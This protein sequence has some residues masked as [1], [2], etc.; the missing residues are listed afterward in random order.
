MEK[1]FS[2]SLAAVFLCLFGLSSNVVGMENLKMPDGE[3]DPKVVGYF[4]YDIKNNKP[5]SKEIPGINKIQNDNLQPT[6][7]IDIINENSGKAINYNGPL[8][9]LVINAS[10]DIS[11]AKMLTS[12]LCHNQLGLKISQIGG[13]HAYQEGDVYELFGQRNVRVIFFDVLHFN[14]RKFMKK[15]DPEFIAKNTNIVL[16]LIDKRH[17]KDCVKQ[18]ENF[19]HNFNHWWCKDYY[20]Y[21]K[22]YKPYGDHR[23]NWFRPVLEGMKVTTVNHR[24]MYFLYY[25]TNLERDKFFSCKCKRNNVSDAHDPNCKELMYDFVSGMPDGRSIQGNLFHENASIDALRNC[26]F[27]E[28]KSFQR[29]EPFD[30]KNTHG[31]LFFG[32][33]ETKGTGFEKKNNMANPWM[34]VNPSGNTWDYWH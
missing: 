13:I 28:F 18:L 11:K 10:D 33:D 21:D 1:S 6:S 32:K 34:G 5:K 9:I 4:G 22:S 7:P 24:Y 19:Y 30:E 25:G 3:A 23:D 17:D 2:R 26:I 15:Y 27:K 12:L 29:T 14:D 16:Y 31:N 8:N 20:P